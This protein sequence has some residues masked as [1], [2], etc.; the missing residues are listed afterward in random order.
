MIKNKAR[1][2]NGHYYNGDRFQACPVC[3]APSQSSAWTGQPTEYLFDEQDEA[4]RTLFLPVDE[5]TSMFD[6]KT[7][8][9]RPQPSPDVPATGAA[10]N[11]HCIV[12]YEPDS[13]TYY[14]RQ[15][16]SAGADHPGGNMDISPARAKAKDRIMIGQDEFLLIPLCEDGFKWEAVFD[17]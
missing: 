12:T 16:E 2:P 4:D 15:G 7:E 13:R 17:R 10:Q 8:F 14:I 6:G 1:C 11:K 9:I 3:G 5:T